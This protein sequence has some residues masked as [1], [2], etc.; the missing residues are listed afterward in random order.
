METQVD[1]KLMLLLLCTMLF[2]S[3][4]FAADEYD[5]G[6]EYDVVVPVSQTAMK[7]YIPSNYD[8]SRK[9]PLVVFYHGMNGSPTTDCIVRHSGG[10]DYLVAGLTYCEKHNSRLTRQQHDAYIVKERKNFRNAVQWV[11]Q[12]LSLDTKRV[13]LGGISKGGWTTSFIG[14]REFPVSALSN[15]LLLPSLIGMAP[16]NLTPLME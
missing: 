16:K 12:N 14:E 9:W 5:S 2:V 13:F 3:S 4:S 15:F 10:E 1:N 6:R 7:I 11:K 8:A